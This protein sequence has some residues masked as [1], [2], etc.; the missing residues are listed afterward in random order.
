MF[1][2]Y[3]KTYHCE[4]SAVR[5]IGGSSVYDVWQ[6]RS[7]PHTTLLGM[8]QQISRL[9]EWQYARVFVRTVCFRSTLRTTIDNLIALLTNMKHNTYKYSAGITYV[10]SLHG[11]I[12]DW[13]TPFYCD[14]FLATLLFVSVRMNEYNKCYCDQTFSNYF[15]RIWVARASA[16]WYVWMSRHLSCCSFLRITCTTACTRH[17]ASSHIIVLTY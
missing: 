1:F 14:L 5:E 10:L 9:S 17:F 13:N 6:L 12:G 7:L 16:S 4:S 11:V 15:P 3:V 8:G 2:S